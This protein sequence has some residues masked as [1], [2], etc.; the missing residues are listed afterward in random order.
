MIFERGSGEGP[1]GGHMVG[2]GSG[3]EV[4][5]GD[6]HQPVCS[7]EAGFHDVHVLAANGVVQ[8][9]VLRVVRRHLQVGQLCHGP[10]P[11]V[12]DVVHHKHAARVRQLVVVAVVRLR[13]TKTSLKF[14]HKGLA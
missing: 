7:Q 5:M 13:G 8:P 10:P 14:D 12:R 9:E 1:E 4:P 6:R 2:G 3:G 11:L